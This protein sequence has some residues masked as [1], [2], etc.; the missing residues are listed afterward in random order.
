MVKVL[1]LQLQHQ[2]SQ[3][4]FRTDFFKDWQV[5]SPCSS[6]DRLPAPAFLGFPCSSAGKESACNA[7]RPEFDPWVRKIPQRRERLPTPIFWPGEFHG[8]YIVC[9]VTKSQTQLSDFHFT[10]FCHISTWFSH[11]YI[12][13]SPHENYII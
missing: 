5:G 8:L 2:S 4:I 11:R 1:E 9:G 3:W 7:G 12:L 10:H 6:R 13:M